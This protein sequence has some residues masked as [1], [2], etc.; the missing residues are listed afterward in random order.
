MR[1]GAGRRRWWR[2][3]G[4]DDARLHGDRDSS[5]PIALEVARRGERWGRLGE[6]EAELFKTAR[7]RHFVEAFTCVSLK[8]MSHSCVPLKSWS[9]PIYPHSNF[10]FP[11]RHSVR[12]L[13]VFCRSEALT[14]GSDR[15]KRPKYPSLNPAF[16]HCLVGPT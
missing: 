8:K 3:A 16:S 4:P 2:S 10:C 6:D 14:C 1:Q 13:L 12:I 9:S 15:T 5:N 11:S 7:P